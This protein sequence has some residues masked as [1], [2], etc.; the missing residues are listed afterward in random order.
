MADTGLTGFD[1]TIQET[2]V[3]LRDIGQAMHDTRRNVA[4]HALRGVL[5]ALRD[6]LTVNEV[7]DFS[8]QL[9]M[10]I[11]GIFFEGYKPTDK[12]EKYHR[13]EFLKRVSK[14]LVQAGGANA[15]AASRAVLAVVQQ[16]VSE[17]EVAKLHHALPKD[18]RA[19][20]GEPT[21]P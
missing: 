3:W 18:L 7:F 17:G 14:E 21:A 6:R 16:H 11:R 10:L 1:R 12:P 19:L 9:P 8:A 4:Y 2:N 13:E 5:F 20:W 15:E